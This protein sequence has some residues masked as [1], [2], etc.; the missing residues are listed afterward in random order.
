MG[1]NAIPF[2]PPVER[3]QQRLVKRT[4]AIQGKRFTNAT[5]FHNPWEGGT[6]SGSRTGEKN[7]KGAQNEAA[8]ADQSA[9]KSGEPGTSETTLG[10]SQESWS[11]YL[12]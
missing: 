6:E 7:S 12:L 8:F 10:V 3:T 1:S 4:R 11:H 2:L 9:L 5:L